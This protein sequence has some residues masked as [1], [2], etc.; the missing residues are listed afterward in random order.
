MSAFDS[1]VGRLH[2][3]PI[4][5]DKRRMRINLPNQITIGRLG[6]AVVFYVLLS[7][8]D[9]RQLAEQRWLLHVSFW[10]FI[11]AALTDV[12]DGYLAR[13]MNA[14]TSFGRVVDPVAD[15]VM[16]CGAFAFFASDHFWDG[17]RNITGVTAWMAV[18]ILTR[19]LL[20]SAIRAHS[21]AGGEAFAA[22]WGGKLKMFIQSF[23]IATIL[24][25]YAWNWSAIDPLRVGAVWATVIVTVLS[26]FTY[27]QRARRFLLSSSALGG[28]TGGR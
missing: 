24:G 22:A 4:T 18:V 14:V 25:Q 27:V 11:V 21:E 9:A 5:E 6:L 28:D 13:T 16:I 3:R 15:K 8:F 26:G 19:E 23:T 12:L 10:V 7:W 2:C 1:V 17:T 20:V